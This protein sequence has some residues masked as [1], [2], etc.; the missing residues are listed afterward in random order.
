MFIAGLRVVVGDGCRGK[1]NNEGRSSHTHTHTHTQIYTHRR[2]LIGNNA[3]VSCTEE[4]DEYK[5]SYLSY[6][7]SC[8]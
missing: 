5:T 8:F 1:E 3:R 4:Y 2:N 6:L 7:K